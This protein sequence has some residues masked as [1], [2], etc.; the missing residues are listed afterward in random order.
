PTSVILT[1]LEHDHID[2]YPT[3][4]DYKQ[5]FQFLIDELP[6]NGFLVVHQ[7]VLPHLDTSKCLAKVFVYGNSHS[8]DIYYEIQGNDSEGT[9]FSFRVKGHE[10]VNK[11]RIPMFGVYNVE[12]AVAVSALSLLENISPSDVLKSLASFPGTR[13]RQELLRVKDGNIAVIRDYAHHPTAVTLTLEG[14]RLRYPGRR[15]I[16]IFEPRSASSTRKDFE[17]RYGEALNQADISIIIKPTLKEKDDKSNSIDISNVKHILEAAGRIAHEAQNFQE[18]LETV[19]TIVNQ[20]DVT[21]FMSSGDMEGI[22][23]KFAK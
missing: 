11:A 7:S 6:P 22:P 4:E 2:L 14:L 1:S 20:N 9:T 13:E 16:A 10:E 8:S 23:E 15:I 3:F 5:A 18:A 17:V 12:N 21:V 19:S